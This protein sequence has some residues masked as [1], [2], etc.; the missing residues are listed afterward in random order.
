[1]HHP[2][3]PLPSRRPR[4]PLLIPSLRRA[5]ESRRPDDP[6]VVLGVGSE[7]RSDDA[8]GVRVAQKLAGQEALRGVHA[9]DGG[10]APEN[11]TAEVRRIRPTHVLIVDAAAMGEQPGTIRFID[12]K[13]VGGA[14][15]GTHGLPLTVLADYLRSELHCEVIIVGIQPLCVEYGEELSAPVADA[16]EE[17]VEALE[18]CLG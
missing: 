3:P 15:F 6:V 7:L 18:E 11:T 4:Q 1:M 16:A 17:L 9:V 14:S 5:L 10:A 12:P 8:V 13:N 2:H